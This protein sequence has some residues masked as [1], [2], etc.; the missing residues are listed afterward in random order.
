MPQER[1]K[2]IYAGS[3]RMKDGE[4]GQQLMVGICLDDIPQ[5]H[6]STDG[7]GR[8]WV[9]VIVANR[10]EPGKYGETHTVKVNTWKP[11]KPGPTQNDS[12]GW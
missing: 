11:D 10:K 1:E 3:G 7:K 6:I 4:Y 8:R 12:G 9:N 5:E 2:P